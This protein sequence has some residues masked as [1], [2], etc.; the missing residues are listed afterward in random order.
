MDGFRFG[1][2]D[3]LVNSRLSASML[4][5]A[6]YL[7]AAAAGADSFWVGDHLNSLIPRSLAT[8]EH[9]G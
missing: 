6:S 9:L 7:T 8:R 3:G 4:P 1:I 5:R 2:L